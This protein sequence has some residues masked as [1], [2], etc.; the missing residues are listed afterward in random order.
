MINKVKQF[1]KKALVASMFLCKH[2]YLFIGI[3]SLSC[4]IAACDVV[5]EVDISNVRQGI[6]FSSTQAGNWDI[7]R[8]AQGHAEMQ[9]LTNTVYIDERFPCWSSVQRSFY[10]RTSEG[11]I[12]NKQIMKDAPE[13]ILNHAEGAKTNPSIS[14]DGKQLLYVNYTIDGE[15][16]DGDIYLLDIESKKNKKIVDLPGHQFNPA[17]S[18]DSK[19]FVFMSGD[20]RG[21]YDIWISS[22]E[23]KDVKYIFQSDF[24][25]NQPHLSSDNKKV[26]FCSTRSGNSD[27]WLYDVKASELKQ[28]TNSPS[29]DEYPKWSPDGKQILFISSKSGRFHAWTM[30]SEGSKQRQIT[31]GDFDVRDANWIILNAGEK[32]SGTK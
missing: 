10:Y 18:F 12:F 26:V 32:S 20:R 16:E 3:V 19:S 28:L 9:Q 1:D 11:D 7:W 13:L 15:T 5:D 31:K 27:I 23:G 8:M 17:W 24:F 30:D 2:N 29:V 6:I 4:L 22:S 14:P 25:D 21:S